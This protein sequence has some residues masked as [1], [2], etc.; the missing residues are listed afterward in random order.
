MRLQN[1]NAVITGASSGIGQA[2]ASHFRREGANLLLTGRRPE[3]QNAAG[4]VQWRPCGHG[5]H[6]LALHRGDRTS[7][8]ASRRW[9]VLA[10]GMPNGPSRA[11]HWLRF[12][13][14]KGIKWGR[15]VRA[16]ATRAVRAVGCGWLS[17]YRPYRRSPRAVCRVRRRT[18]CC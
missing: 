5:R 17:P 14:S 11:V 6:D 18:G 7:A 15:A 8:D 1:V 4:H 13:L 2:V 16:P 10:A 9:S 3:P 12:R